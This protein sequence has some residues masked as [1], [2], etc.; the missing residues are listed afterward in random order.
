MRIKYVTDVTDGTSFLEAVPGE[1]DGTPAISRLLF[2]TP[3]NNVSPDRIAVAGILAFGKYIS[4]Q[5]VFDEKMSALTAQTIEQ[6]L[7]PRWVHVTPLHPANLPIPR[8]NAH[9]HLSSSIK[10]LVHGD[11]LLILKGL[12]T[13]GVAYLEA[14]VSV[15]SNALLLDA[16]DSATSWQTFGA[17]LA[18]GVLHSADLDIAVLK[19]R[20]WSAIQDSDFEK[21]RNLL[22]SC[23]LGISR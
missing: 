19:N 1:L 21:L 15:P 4:G 11:S 2:P 12:P 18:V 23:G 14:I 10:E 5:V 9:I 20:E 16:V 17:T 7:E 8:G 3:K 13:Q 22:S 6:F